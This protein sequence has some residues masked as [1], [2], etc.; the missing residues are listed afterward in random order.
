MNNEI[1]ICYLADYKLC[2]LLKKKSLLYDSKCNMFLT[3]IHILHL[4]SLTTQ[5]G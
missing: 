5:R 2:T 4:L 3:Y 1:S